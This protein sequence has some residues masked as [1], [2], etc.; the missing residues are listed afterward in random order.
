M[1][2]NELSNLDI[3]F[4]GESAALELALFWCW[5]CGIVLG[6]HEGSD[7]FGACQFQF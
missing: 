2:G 7:V 5:G 6:V 4:K 1:D 3:F